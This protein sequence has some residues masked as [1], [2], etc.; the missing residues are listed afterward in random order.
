MNKYYIN[1]SYFY[2]FSSIFIVIFDITLLHKNYCSQFI[3]DNVSIFSLSTQIFPGEFCKIYKNTFVIEQFWATASVLQISGAKTCEYFCLEIATLYWT[4]RQLYS[5][6]FQVLLTMSRNLQ[7]NTFAGVSF[8]IKFQTL[9]LQP[10][11]PV[12]SCEFC[13]MFK[14]TLIEQLWATASKHSFV[15]QKDQKSEES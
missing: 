4:D 7:G 15:S 2:Q 6:L 14:N 11:T 12:F 13:K 10:P 5:Y 9:H 8:S 3:T 1:I